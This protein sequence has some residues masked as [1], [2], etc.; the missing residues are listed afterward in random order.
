MS[1]RTTTTVARRAYA[2]NMDEPRRRGELHQSIVIARLVDELTGEPVRGDVR[3]LSARRG[4]RPKTAA[5]GIAGVAGVPARLFPDLD[6]QPYSIDL[7]FEAGG[8][9]TLRLPAVTIPPQAGFPDAFAGV[10]LGDLAL[11]R[12]PVGLVV[13]TLRLDAQ[14]RPVPLG[15]ATVEVT[16]IWRRLGDLTGP[17]SA[18]AVVS[19]EPGVHAPRPQ[20]G[21]TLSP[22]TLTPIVEPACTLVGAVEAGTTR[23]E[24]SRRGALA[25]GAVVGIDRADGERAEHIAVDQVVGPA[26][27]ASPAAV[28]LVFPVQRAHAEG[29]GVERVTPAP[30]GPTAG[31]TV[32][33]RP[34]D[35]TV[36]V[37]ST[38]PFTSSP[39]VRISGGPA[40]DEYV[41]T[42]PYRAV[43]G[44]DGYG[45]M[46]ALSRVA[47]VEITA[48]SPGPLTTGPR[49]FTPRYGAPENRLDLTLE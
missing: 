36:F 23:L 22:A 41:V 7:A 2:A 4:I 47:A 10:E 37:S 45:R 24:V 35:A 21:T 26:D 49:W 11:R 38:A 27:A 33:A 42:A 1:G 48:T 43:T 44:V 28:L 16:G 13:R 18:A 17:A 32:D 15:G 31:L 25:P 14:G 40:P 12:I 6:V 20:V 29:A 30:V 3:V 5:G 46:A 19:I 9:V 8:F 34:G 39:A